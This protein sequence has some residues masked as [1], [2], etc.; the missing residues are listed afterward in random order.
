MRAGTLFGV[1]IKIDTVLLIVSPAVV[2]FAGGDTLIAIFTAIFLHECCHAVVAAAFGM[3][4]KCMRLSPFGGTAVIEDMAGSGYEAVVAAAGP[5]FSLALGGLAVAAGMYVPSRFLERLAQASFLLAAFNM[6][7]A[8]P[9]DGGRILRASLA[10]FMPLKKATAIASGFGAVIGAFLML[11]GVYYLIMG[12]I[13]PTALITGGWLL[14]ASISERSRGSYNLYSAV[15]KRQDAISLGKRMR[16]RHIAAASTTSAADIAAALEP[17]KYTLI[18]V[19]GR[20]G[21]IIG[22]LSEGELLKGIINA[23]GTVSIGRLV[24]KQ[25]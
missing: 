5:L 23:K 15:T 10:S 20:D 24:S 14:L 11:G 25:G 13:R 7:P 19:I 12:S 8:F 22:E 9:L 6:L 4:V 17:G 21:Q 16:I 1:E 2:L 18:K 3:R